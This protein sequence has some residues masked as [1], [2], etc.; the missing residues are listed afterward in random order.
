MAGCLACIFVAGSLQ[1]PE[2]DLP[3]PPG[4]KKPAHGVTTETLLVESHGWDTTL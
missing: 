2:N 1:P 3:K 4:K